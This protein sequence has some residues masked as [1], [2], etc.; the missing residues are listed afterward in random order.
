MI[1]SGRA[2]HVVRVRVRRAASRRSLVRPGVQAHRARRR[3][4]LP[5]P[6]SNRRPTAQPLTASYSGCAWTLGRTSRYRGRRSVVYPTFGTLIGSGRS[7]ARRYPGRRRRVEV[8]R[9][10]ES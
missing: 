5:T 8:E 1:G 10:C 6:A 4:F 2:M 9:G 7:G 3:L